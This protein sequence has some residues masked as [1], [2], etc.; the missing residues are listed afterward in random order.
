[1]SD[2]LSIL[3]SEDPFCLGF[4]AA[5]VYM[6]ARLNLGDAGCAYKGTVCYAMQT[7][8]HASVHE[9]VFSVDVVSLQCIQTSIFLKQSNPKP[10]AK[11]AHCRHGSSV[12]LD[13]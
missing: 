2:S 13:L 5:A 3:C 9:C 1:M 4:A 7:I 11:S 10:D 6:L 8:H 12:Y